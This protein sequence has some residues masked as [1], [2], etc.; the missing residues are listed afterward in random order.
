MH[1]PMSFPT[2]YKLMK[3]DIYFFLE[4]PVSF[5]FFDCGM[6]S[7]QSAFFAIDPQIW[8]KGPNL[9][10]F[11]RTSTYTLIKSDKALLQ[12]E[13]LNPLHRSVISS[14]STVSAIDL[15]GSTKPNY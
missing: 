7:S 2:F 3:L 15:T 11:H 12:V 5:V 9:E 1:F 8:V 13:S 4:H 6:V 14:Q 10:T